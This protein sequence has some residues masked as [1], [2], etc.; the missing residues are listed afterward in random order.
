MGVRVE[1]NTVLRYSKHKSQEE[2]YYMDSVEAE[3]HTGIA[4]HTTENRS[5][6]TGVADSL[7]TMIPSDC[8]V[9]LQSLHNR[10]ELECHNSDSTQLLLEVALRIHYTS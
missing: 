9:K 5:S 10:P 1:V 4:R 8:L 3:H 2:V 6:Y 7:V